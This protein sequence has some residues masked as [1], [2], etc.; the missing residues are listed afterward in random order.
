MRASGNREVTRDRATESCHGFNREEWSVLV[1]NE[2]PRYAAAV[3][4][5]RIY[6]NNAQDA[7][8][9]AFAGMR[10][11]PVEVIDDDETRCF[12]DDA[13]PFS[14]ETSEELFL[15]YVERMETEHRA[16]ATYPPRRQD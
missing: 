8:S 12:F 3:S 6:I 1:A 2:F 14:H 11:T 4:L 15:R 10:T 7:R 9:A 13:K 5:S 16:V